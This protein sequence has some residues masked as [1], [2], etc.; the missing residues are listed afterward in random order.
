MIMM[1]IIINSRRLR[2]QRR[3]SVGGEGADT[4]GALPPSPLLRFEDYL[5]KVADL[6]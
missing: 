3:S 2:N 4:S 6:V 1:I 5:L